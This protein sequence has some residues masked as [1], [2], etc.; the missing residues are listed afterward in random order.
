V[1]AKPENTMT[2]KPLLPILTCLALI[3]LVGCEHKGPVEKAGEKIDHTADTIKNGGEEP[4]GDKL[5]DEA[6]KA[7]DKM[8]KAT[9]DSK[10][11]PPQ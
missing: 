3:A 1:P 2:R 5:Q 11:H 9:K 4:T 7:Q 10:R 6:D 8:S